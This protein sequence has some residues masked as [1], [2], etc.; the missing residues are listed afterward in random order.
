MKQLLVFA[1]AVVTVWVSHLWADEAA[2]KP[3]PVPATRP[4][5]K[6]A[7]EA[8]KQQKLR[9][10]PPTSANGQASVSN[11]LPKTWGGGGGLG[12]FGQSISRAARDRSGRLPDPRSDSLF[13][14]A[15]FWVVS[16][17]NNCHYCLGHQELKLRA[18]GL[19]DNTIAALD[20]DWTVFSLRQ[21]AAL[22]YARKLTLEPHRIGVKDIAALKPLFSDAEIIELSFNIA[23]FNS[24][25]R[26]AD[27]IG[28]PQERHLSAEG[29]IK[30]TT[31]TDQPFQHTQ[32]VVIPPEREPRPLLATFDQVQQAIAATR[33]R[34]A[35]VTLPP[36]QVARRE[37]ADA[38]GSREPYEWERAL[39][40][41]PV[42][43]KSQVRTWSA[44]LGD[45]NL[46]PRLKAELAFITAVNNR[47][48]YASAH[49][50]HRMMQL[51]AA[52][53]DLASLLNEKAE[54][55]RGIAAAYRLAAKSTTDPHLIADADITQVRKHF[56][57]AATAQIIHVIC[58]ANLF[59]RFTEALGLP[60]EA[61]IYR[62]Q[63]SLPASHD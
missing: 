52:P 1:S 24:V 37:L 31:P 55:M 27:A 29:E 36:V 17:G 54:S 51:G 39:A 5:L 47:A 4:E 9:I 46:S 11:Y 18:G 42:I 58:M 49:A 19:E 14:D 20:S 53:E 32:S 60:L 50:A 41:L 16:R 3:K 44:I 12:G 61:N 56:G 10:P 23:L 6:A 43:G 8:L 40:Q 45:D 13:T 25:N 26:W 34:A 57:D 28:L 35:R 33:S 15:C 48:W 30:F 63:H 21:Q 38:I 7:L 2:N 62:A 22:N 59:D